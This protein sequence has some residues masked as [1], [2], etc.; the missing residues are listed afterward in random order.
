[1]KNKSRRQ[2]ARLAAL[3]GRVCVREPH[4]H[5][6]RVRNCVS[7]ALAVTARPSV[8]HDSC[9]VSAGRVAWRIVPRTRRCALSSAAPQS[10]RQVGNRALTTRGCRA[11]W[12][13]P[14]SAGAR[15]AGRP[16]ASSR[17]PACVVPSRIPCC[18]QASLA[19]RLRLADYWPVDWRPLP[20]GAP[21]RTL[22]GRLTLLMAT[23]KIKLITA[24]KLPNCDRQLLAGKDPLSAAVQHG[25]RRRTKARGRH[26][27]AVDVGAP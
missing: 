14:S 24:M 27:G 12:P 20:W 17:P 4:Y 16:R 8:R 21:D 13:T 2:A 9:K 7:A 11:G 3:A 15:R 10:A 23:T 22:A 19:R 25:K 18:V 6:L 5:I 26:G 1:M